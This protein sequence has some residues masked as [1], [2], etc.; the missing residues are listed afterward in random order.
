MIRDLLKYLFSGK[1]KQYQPSASLSRL[2]WYKFRKNKVAM[3]ALLFVGASLLVSI[4][5]YLITPDST[6]YANNQN[7][8]L[9][10]LPPGSKV[11][12]LYIRKNV[13]EENTSLLKKM[14]SGEKSRHIQKPFS[15]YTFQKDGIVLQEYGE[16]SNHKRNA[17]T[18]NIADVLFSLN[19]DHKP[20]EKNNTIHYTL[21]NGQEK[22]AGIG[23]LRKKVK[24]D[25]I[26]TK[27][28]LLGTDRFGRDLL[29]R[30]LIGT[31]VSLSV[32]FISVLI[33]LIVGIT[34][35]SIAG[36]FRGRI[37]DLIVWFINV[38]WSI[39]TLLLVIAITFALGKG[40]WQVFIAVG[41][42]MWVEV[43][44][45]VRGQ[46]I[47]IREKEF[48]EAGRALGF[49]NYRIIVRHIL[50]NV[51]APVI[52]ISAANFA[53]AILIEAGLSF[54]GLGVQPPMPS[55]G[56]M[57]KEH[58][59]YLVLDSAYLAVL[60]GLAI[61]LMVLAFML[62]GNALREALDVKSY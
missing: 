36:F 42:T 12:V 26:R 1:K 15:S 5:G 27:N 11:D 55:W 40:F 47:S 41:L 58:Y 9:I 13:P 19:P 7:L 33:S 18:Y 48:V 57:I 29:S 24:Q 46:I 2:A 32:G 21:L 34:L 53:A 50:P 31:R 3:G 52:V 62:I 61:V 6:P 51:M 8:E 59:G 10:T 43:A 45:V 35:G 4:A 14:T 23:E 39:P 17:Y 56:T 25:N 30:L 20:Y 44:R 54:L 38:V 16:T 49:S 28:F 60:P 37:D 22:T